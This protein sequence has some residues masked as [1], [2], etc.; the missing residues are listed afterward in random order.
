MQR[1]WRLSR[2]GESGCRGR[3]WISPFRKP[4][5]E[6]HSSLEIPYLS[7]R[8]AEAAAL[9]ALWAALGGVPGEDE[10]LD[11]GG[12]EL[13]PRA[14][15]TASLEQGIGRS[16]TLGTVHGV[17]DKL[18]AARDQGLEMV[19]V[20]AGQDPRD[21]EEHHQTRPDDPIPM[22]T[23]REV[24]ERLWTL[25]RTMRNYHRH[26]WEHWTEQW[27]EEPDDVVSP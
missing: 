24:L 22:A 20:A 21:F 13:D 18:R 5:D 9:C 25:P 23:C 17:R 12:L 1:A 8:S 6:E 10:E 15:V 3:W 7:G 2:A 11:P 4:D 26:V 14:T 19:L 16:I 27:S